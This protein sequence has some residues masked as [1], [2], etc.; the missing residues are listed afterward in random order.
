VEFTDEK[1]YLLSIAKWALG[2]EPAF[3]KE[4]E[5]YIFFDNKTIPILQR[6]FLFQFFKKTRF[7]R[8]T[9]SNSTTKI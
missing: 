3:F 6:H 1:N 2:G 9:F 4:T 8:K 5:E 7:L